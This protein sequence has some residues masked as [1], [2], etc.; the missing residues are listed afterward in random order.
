MSL[1]QIKVTCTFLQSMQE[2]SVYTNYNIELQSDLTTLEMQSDLTALEKVFYIHYV[3][4]TQQ[5][6]IK[7]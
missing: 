6:N 4:L 3:C 2:R 7:T 1:S 5:L